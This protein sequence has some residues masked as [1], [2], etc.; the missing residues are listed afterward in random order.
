ML[1]QFLVAKTR[2]LQVYKRRRWN[3]GEFWLHVACKKIVGLFRNTMNCHDG[4]PVTVVGQRN[5][6]NGR[7][8]HQHPLCGIIVQVG[9][10]ICFLLT[11]VK[12]EGQK[13]D[14]LPWWHTSYCSWTT[15][16]WEW[17]IMPT[18]SSVWHYC[19]SWICDPFPAHHCQN[20]VG[21]CYRSIPCRCR[22]NHLFGRLPWE[23]QH[24]SP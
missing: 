12:I 6:G 15:Q 8:C 1:L 5:C 2:C 20:K 9:S 7:S 11:I 23:T 19:P 3:Q 4:T 17:Q 14:K 18:T 21:V 24:V 10:V 16:L 22:C 13:H